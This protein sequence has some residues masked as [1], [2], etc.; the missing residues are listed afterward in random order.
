[1][2]RTITSKI[3]ID[4]PVQADRDFTDNEHNGYLQVQWANF[5]AMRDYKRG[6]ALETI[7]SNN[8]RMLRHP[9]A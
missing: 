9:K 2:T 1:M 8:Y 7:R 5:V 4:T 6:V 3:T